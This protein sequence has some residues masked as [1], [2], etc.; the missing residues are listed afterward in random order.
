MYIIE[1]NAITLPPHKKKNKP[2]T[3]NLEIFSF[4]YGA[5]RRR[6]DARGVKGSAHEEPMRRE[7]KYT[8]TV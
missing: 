8:L 4:L 2:I 1:I 3:A 7:N 6:R 5:A